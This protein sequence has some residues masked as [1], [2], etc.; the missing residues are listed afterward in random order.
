MLFF[1]IADDKANPRHIVETANSLLLSGGTFIIAKKNLEAWESMALGTAWYNTAF[2]SP[3]SSETYPLASYLVSLSK[4]A[5]L[6]I[7]NSEDADPF[8]FC[9]NAQKKAWSNQESPEDALVD[10][11]DSF[12]YGYTF[13]NELDLQWEFPGLN[14]TQS[15]DIWITSTEGRDGNAAQGLVR[16][17]RREYV[18]WTIRLV[19]F[20]ESC[21][22]DMRQEFLEHLPLELRH[23]QDILVSPKDPNV[24]LVPRIPPVPQVEVSATTK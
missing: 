19:I 15:L 13:G 1:N 23:E 22:E 5:V 8:H 18:S 11:V 21:D 17:M 24:L 9:I 14:S 10:P 16:A 4:F 6:C 7:H 20:P 2:G 12:I 3:S